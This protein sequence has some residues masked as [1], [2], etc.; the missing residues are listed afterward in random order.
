M[1]AAQSS[2]MS[3]PDYTTTLFQNENTTISMY[4]TTFDK[5]FDVINTSQY[6]ISLHFYRL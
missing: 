1:E 6:K 4:Y 5:V 2:E 3:V